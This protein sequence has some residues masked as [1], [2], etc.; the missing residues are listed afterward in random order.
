MTTGFL[1]GPVLLGLGCWGSKKITGNGDP[2]LRERSGKTGLNETV[3]G[4]RERKKKSPKLSWGLGGWTCKQ[5]LREGAGMNEAANAPASSPPQ[6]GAGSMREAPGEGST[7]LLSPFLD[8]AFLPHFPD[9]SAFPPVP[10]GR[11]DQPGLP[12]PSSAHTSQVQF[13]GIRL[14][15]EGRA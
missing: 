13:K 4:G 12:S 3:K 14:S 1:D 6:Q 5:E 8:S 9:S 15:G 11:G 10:R 7:S 2:G